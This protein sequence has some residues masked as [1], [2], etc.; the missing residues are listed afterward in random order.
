[1]NEPVSS[2]RSFNP[3][4][5]IASGF[6]VVWI[7]VLVFFLPLASVV[8]VPWLSSWA[9]SVR[10]PPVPADEVILPVLTSA[11]AATA[12]VAV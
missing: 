4:W 3:W 11:P 10:L 9:A 8:R 7:V 5:L 2:T 12:S 6:G 1:M